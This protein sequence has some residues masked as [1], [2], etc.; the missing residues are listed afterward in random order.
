TEA[1]FISQLTHFSDDTLRRPFALIETKVQQLRKNVAKWF[2]FQSLRNLEAEYV[3]N[4]LADS[5]AHW[6]QLLTEIKKAR[7]T[8]DTSE[9][10][11]S[12]SVFMVMAQGVEVVVVVAFQRQ[13]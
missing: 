7:A 2:Q 12:F 4:R 1:P 5:L 9:K 13:R 3:F 11:G 6:Q 10:Q 8:F